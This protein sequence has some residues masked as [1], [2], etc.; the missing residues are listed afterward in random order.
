MQISL[1][2]HCAIDSI[3]IDKSSYEQIGGAACYGS[4]TAHN[5]KFNVRLHTKYGSDF[6]HEKL[7]DQKNIT[8]A[9]A[10]SDSLTTRFKIIITGD[11]RTL[12]LKS[13]CD[14]IPYLDINSDGVIVSPIF[15]EISHDV[16]EQIKNNSNFVFLDPQGFLRRKNSEQKI[17]LEKTELDLSKISAIKTNPDELFNL[18]GK[19]EVDGMLDLQKR[20]VEHVLYTNKRNIS[21]LTQDR[22]YSIELPKI[23]IYDTTGVGDI[24]CAAFTC[25]MLK[26]KEAIWALCFAG[27]AAQAAL[28]RR[29]VG[30]GKVPGKNKIETNAAYF[31]NLLKFEQV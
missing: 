8:Y 30:L 24:F 15:D 17:F 5:L 14:P 13:I 20:G 22:I 3:E 10:L 31:Y 11:E 6:P 16:L 25:T 19:Y 9:D 21:L 7:F 1:Y 4:F 12:Y 27:G 29:K 2:S 18:T 26:E 28:E 23:N